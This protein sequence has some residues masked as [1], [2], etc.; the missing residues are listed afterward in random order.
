MSEAIVQ[1]TN[2]QYNWVLLIVLFFVNSVCGY[3]YLLKMQTVPMTRRNVAAAMLNSGLFGAA[4]FLMFEGYFTNNRGCLIGITVFSGLGGNP[5]MEAAFGLWR[6]G[7]VYFA[8][9]KFPGF[10]DPEE[11]KKPD[12]K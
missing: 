1:S 11:G 6:S 9:I 3:A 12:A 5:I 4:I 8:K 7:M 2:G 10:Q